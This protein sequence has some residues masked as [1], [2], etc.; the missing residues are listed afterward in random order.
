MKDS[1]KIE[2]K[3]KYVS[4]SYADYSIPIKEENLPRPTSC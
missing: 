4:K 3:K 2:L 1:T